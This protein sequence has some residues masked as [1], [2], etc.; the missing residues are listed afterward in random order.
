MAAK[1]ARA[2]ETDEGGE[3]ARARR[4]WRSGGCGAGVVLVSC[5][6]GDHK[7]R[8]KDG[9]HIVGKTVLSSSSSIGDP[10]LSLHRLPPKCPATGKMLAAGGA[11]AAA[12]AGGA[13]AIARYR[14]SS[15]A[16]S[17]ANPSTSEDPSG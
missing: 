11:A 1:K 7:L 4:A 12:I 6:L 10:S 13:A 9:K 3:R 14:T 2:A 5:S 8:T 15:D 16:G 17:E